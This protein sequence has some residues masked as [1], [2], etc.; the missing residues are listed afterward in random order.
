MRASAEAA[1]KS[2]IASGLVDIRVHDLRVDFD[3][4]RQGL[5]G[6]ERT[7]GADHPMLA[8]TIPTGSAYPT[9]TVTTPKGAYYVRVQSFA[10]GLASAPSNEIRLFVNTPAPPSVFTVTGWSGEP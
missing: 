10:A 3:Q 4:R 9:F 2:E 5:A 6:R 1:F 7:Q 8:P